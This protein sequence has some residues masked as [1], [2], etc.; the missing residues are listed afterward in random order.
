MI[1]ECSGGD[2][3]GDIVFTLGS[4]HSLNCKA[5]HTNFP[6]AVPRWTRLGHLAQFLNYKL[7]WLNQVDLSCPMPALHRFSTP[8]QQPP[9][10]LHSCCNSFLL[11]FLLQVLS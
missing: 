5:I 7:P 1:C 11:H 2:W 6:T 8:G 4:H 3:G 9:S 10:A